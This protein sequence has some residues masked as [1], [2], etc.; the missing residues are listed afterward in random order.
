MSKIH[1]P[2]E[3]E[4][5]EFYQKLIR[6][7]AFQD[8]QLVANTNQVAGHAGFFSLQ[9]ISSICLKP[10]NTKCVRG[11]REHLFYQLVEFCKR[12]DDLSATSTSLST[13]AETAEMTPSNFA[14]T[15]LASNT[16]SI[17][18][19][20]RFEHFPLLTYPSP[21]TKCK[22][23]IDRALL[24]L[25]SPYIAEFYNVRHLDDSSDFTTNQFRQ[26]HFFRSVY[27]NNLSCPCYGRN[28]K[29][30]STCSRD[31]DKVDFLSLEDLASNCQ[32]PC[33]IDI[34]IGQITYDP[35]AI[36]EKV[37]E[38]SSKYKRL[39]EFGFRI[40]GMK[41]GSQIK[42]KTFGRTLETTN[43]V[44]EALDSFLMPIEKNE[45]KCTVISKILEEIESLLK[46]FEEKNINQWRF[47]SSSLLIIYDSYINAASKSTNIIQDELSKSVKVSMIDFAHVF[48]VHDD[49]DV[50]TK[51]KDDNYIYGLRKLKEFFINMY[52]CHQSL[53]LQDHPSHPHPPHPHLPPG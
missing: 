45:Y 14:T 46:W 4:P 51:Q 10:F 22:C 16:S 23:I 15:V 53:I 13:S 29:E 25:L 32:E 24:K 35:M 28:P 12:G 9:S 2:P 7:M 5:E 3:L 19:N 1:D 11:R 52:Q 39:R 48:H 47:F 37:M 41:L 38:Q 36:K 18:R 20:L 44:Y 43:Q 26:E 27:S 17:A 21:A 33:I 50:Q 34:K 6:P 40:L 31:Y 30:K 8:D 49:E 42:D